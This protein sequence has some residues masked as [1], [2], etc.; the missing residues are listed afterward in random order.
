MIQRV[1]NYNGGSPTNQ[2]VL[3]LVDFGDGGD[4]MPADHEWEVMKSYT[5]TTSGWVR[6]SIEHDAAT[7]V[8][9]AK[10]DSDTIVYSV[11]SDFNNDKQVEP[12]DYVAWRKG[13][14]IVERIGNKWHG[15]LRTITTRGKPISATPR[16]Q[17]LL[18]SF[19][20]AIAKTWA[21]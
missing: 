3:Q 10:K 13:S 5:M 4:S 2:V 8:I 17:A 6:L 19:T 16:R 20:L 7:G 14:S 1:E 18:A 12:A 15:A 21:A 9:T 11:P